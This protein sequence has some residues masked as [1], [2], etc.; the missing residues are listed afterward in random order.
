MKIII[1]IAL[2]AILLPTISYGEEKRHHQGDEHAVGVKALSSDL[3]DL[4][5]REMQAL[6]SGMTSIIPAY[7]SGNWEE[8]EM[9][10]RKMKDS[11]ILKQSLTESQIKELHSLLPPAFIEKDQ[12]FHYLAGMLEH[13]AKNKNRELIN[14]YFSKMNES[15]ASCHTQFATHRFP[16]LSSNNEEAEH[17]H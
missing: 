11:Y 3:R 12:E 8:I 6:Q 16:A 7:V 2:L 13:V 15:C 10:A 17:S 1:H 9:T 14:F 4:L 5:A